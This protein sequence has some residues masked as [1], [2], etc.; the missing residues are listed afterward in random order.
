MS[1]SV[2]TE[3]Q[4]LEQR[5]T[6]FSTRLSPMLV[7]ELRQGLRTNL[8]VIAFILLQTFMMLCLFAGLA[9]PSSNGATGFFWFFITTTLLIIQPV[10]GFSALSSEYQLNT[11][12]LI[13]LTRLDAWRITLGKWTALNA[14]GLLFVIGVLPYLVLRYF[15]GNVD[16]GNDFIALGGLTIGSGL[17]TAITIGCSAFRNVIVRVI[18]S[19]GLGFL[20]FAL[21][22]ALRI[23]PMMGR[24]SSYEW[25]M[26]LLLVVCAIY[27]IFFFLSF[28]ASRISPLS[29]NLATRKRLIAIGAALV[30]Q[31]FYLLGLDLE[32]M[33][34]TSFILGL[35]IIDALT[36]P[37][38]I[39]SRV[40]KPFARSRFF[41]LTAIF[42]APGWISGLGFSV[43]AT[44]I[45]IASTLVCE[46][47]A[48]QV[49][50]SEGGPFVTFLSSYNISLF[51]LVIIHIFFARHSSYN[52][53]FGIYLFIQAALFFL[54]LMVSALASAMER[55]AELV[56]LLVPI[57]S[58][59]AV[60]AN[61]SEIEVPILLL[62]AVAT[63]I[64]CIGFPLIR[65]H[66]RVR[67]F[68]RE[69]KP[70]R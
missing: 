48:G 9:D 61:D 4:T 62:V 1:E 52:F 7:K 39:Y 16:I 43:L 11:M 18:I 22:Q 15:L 23:L 65:H 31:G 13:Q 63:T 3:P 66:R 37:L 45:T 12:D 67:E 60:A 33:V 70:I 57:P 59:I 29:D 21:Y 20:V 26:L 69:W 44:A 50:I 41:R 25:E 68:I 27:G 5:L 56:Y 17:A 64:V 10:R 34:A 47:V 32:V 14:Q 53:T 6:D 58:V 46:S 35:A 54:T 8:F 51:P 36:E 49:I 38:P 2:P 24:S 30:C 19:V 40:L 55:W 28:G 42:L